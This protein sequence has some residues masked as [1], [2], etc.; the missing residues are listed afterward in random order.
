MSKQKQYLTGRD[1]FCII[2]TI[3]IFGITL[4]LEE[5]SCLWALIIPAVIIE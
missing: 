4:L 1:W 3:G 2:A 5:P